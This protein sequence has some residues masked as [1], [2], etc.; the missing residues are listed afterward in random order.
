VTGTDRGELA[1]AVVTAINSRDPERLA[2]LLHPAVEVRTGR[3]VRSGADEALAWADKSYDH[4]DRRYAVAVIRTT[5]DRILLAGNVE[6]VWRESAV[7]G[8]SAPI[9]L[10]MEFDGDLLRIL[11]VADDPAAA[12]DDFET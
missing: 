4:L 6:Y 5:G 9:A 8:D 10:T 11:S 12:L 2:K 1:S 7:V 3:S